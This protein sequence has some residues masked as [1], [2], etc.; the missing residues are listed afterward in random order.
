MEFEA[1]EESPRFGRGTFEA[2]LEGAFMCRIFPAVV[3][4][5]ALWLPAESEIP[6]GDREPK[7]G[8]VQRTR[9]SNGNHAVLS[10]FEDKRIL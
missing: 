6:F 3:S 1:K 10:P 4:S 2:H 7:L 5:I 8:V 9:V